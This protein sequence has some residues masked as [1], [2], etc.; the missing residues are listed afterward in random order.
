MLTA[1][2]HQLHLIGIFSASLVQARQCLMLAELDIP[3]LSSCL[4][5]GTGPD[6]ALTRARA[7]T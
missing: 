4:R 5:K 3:S 6:G 1:N 2:I 7:H